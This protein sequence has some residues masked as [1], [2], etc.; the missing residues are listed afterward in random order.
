MKIEPRY[1]DFE[2]SKLLK[3]KG[4]ELEVKSMWIHNTTEPLDDEYYI[5]E[6]TEINHNK[7][8]EYVSAPEIW[9]VVEWL[10][11]VHRI[12]THTQW[13]CTEDGIRLYVYVI[14]GTQSKKCY[15]SP[16]EAQLAAIS[17]ILKNIELK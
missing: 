1:V 17:N 16:K 3:E 15:T 8:P 6:T 12:D 2:T 10:R 14:D 9:Q 7:Y 5:R 13:D 4:F 11:V